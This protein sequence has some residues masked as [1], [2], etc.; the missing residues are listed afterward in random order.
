M[1]SVADVAAYLQKPRGWVYNNWR[2]EGIPFKRVGNQLRCRS[3]DL[4]KWVDGR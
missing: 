1:L 2:A 4:E 3:T